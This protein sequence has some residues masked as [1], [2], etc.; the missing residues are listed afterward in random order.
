LV[1]L[2]VVLAA[3]AWWH[4]RRDRP[5]PIRYREAGLGRFEVKP[6]EGVL[7][8]AD[9]SFHLER[10]RAADGSRHW[11][12]V[13]RDGDHQERRQLDQFPLRTQR[14]EVELATQGRRMTFEARERTPSDDDFAATPR[15]GQPR[16]T[17][18]PLHPSSWSW[19]GIRIQ[20]PRELHYQ[21]STDRRERPSSGPR[22]PVARLL[23]AGVYMA[24]P[25]TLRAAVSDWAF[26]THPAPM[27][28]LRDLGAGVE[29]HRATLHRI[30]G[31][32]L[33]LVE[34]LSISYAMPSPPLEVPDN[35]TRREGAPFVADIGLYLQARPEPWQLAVHAELGPLRSNEVVI[36][37]LP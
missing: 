4:Q 1:I 30:H 34:G 12:G 3:G 8:A 22:K 26:S 7:L 2:V 10:G 9:V 36:H 17:L 31:D 33:A 11:V 28:V 32:Y 5:R 20:A 25:A 6:W 23:I 24:R 16:S 15:D 14:L 19:E 29:L 37:V 21:R 27:L 18:I 35:G 13:V